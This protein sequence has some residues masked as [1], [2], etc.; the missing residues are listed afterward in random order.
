MKTKYIFFFSGTATAKTFLESV[1]KPK[2]NMF[3][4][5]ITTTKPTQPK[6]TCIAF[7]EEHVCHHED[8][9]RHL[10]DADQDVDRRHQN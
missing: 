6:K 4:H 9:D 3:A 10:Q 8:A 1:N 5:G 7:L 2:K